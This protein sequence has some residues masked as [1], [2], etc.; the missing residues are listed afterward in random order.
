MRQ[1]EKG[2][3]LIQLLIVIAISAIIAAGAG[4]TTTQTNKLS[5]RNNDRMTVVRQV[6]NVGY[7]FSQ[8]ALIAQTISTEDDPETTDVEFIIVFWKDWETGD[9]YDIRYV[10][11]DLADSTKKLIRKQT[12]RD[13][14][15]VEIG[16]E[17]TPIAYNIHTA[18]LS[19]QDGAWR[20]SVEAH[21]GEE[22]L[23]RE[24]GIARRLELET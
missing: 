4:V 13:K 7:R 17:T 24:Y 6:Q 3:T 16:N 14:D 19:W 5:Q 20:L 2:S 22:S 23:T 8:D 10:W 9:T 15:G 1:S 11:L 18:S 12:A 21:S